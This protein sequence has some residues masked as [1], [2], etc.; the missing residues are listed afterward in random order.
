MSKFNAATLRILS[1]CYPS[2][3]MSVT[4]K[5]KTVTA[6]EKKPG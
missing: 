1:W 2:T 3:R 4:N 5:T 6:P